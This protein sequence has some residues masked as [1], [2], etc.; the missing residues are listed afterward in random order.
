MFLIQV[1][2]M[3]IQTLYRDYK[4]KKKRKQPPSHERLWKK[5]SYVSINLKNALQQ[6]TADFFRETK[7]LKSIIH[8]AINKIVTLYYCREH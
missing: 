5:I 7:Q 1:V 2:A 4:E 6:T 8:L 3:E